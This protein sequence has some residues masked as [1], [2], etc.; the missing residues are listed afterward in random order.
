MIPRPYF[1]S[2]YLLS[3]PKVLVKYAMACATVNVYR[4]DV[5]SRHCLGK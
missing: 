3:I 5:I 4:A 2:M 1:F